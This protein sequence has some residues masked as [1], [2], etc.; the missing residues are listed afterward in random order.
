MTWLKSAQYVVAQMLGAMLAGR[1]EDFAGWEA[2]ACSERFM[3][4]G[5]RW[6]S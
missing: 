2:V 4:L 3:F 5:V 6:F 1:E